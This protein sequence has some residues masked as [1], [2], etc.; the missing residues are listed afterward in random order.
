MNRAVAKIFN[1]AL[2]LAYIQIGYG[3]GSYD[4]WA[5]TMR[6][7]PG[8]SS[9]VVLHE[10]VHRYFDVNRWLKP[11]WGLRDEEGIAYLLEDYYEAIPL[12][13]TGIRR[14][15]DRM[16]DNIGDCVSNH[17][18]LKE[19][20]MRFGE[21]YGQLSKLDGKNGLGG[22]IN[23]KF[24]DAD[25]NRTYYFLNAKLDCGKLARELNRLEVIKNCCFTF[26]CQNTQTSGSNGGEIV[27]Q[28]GVE[29]DGCFQ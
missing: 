25:V 14:V 4:R 29:I 28:P 19:G 22:F 27:I 23:H 13:H 10:M 11:G 26:S 3:E 9:A 16:S 5:N 6:L 18:L 1:I 24:T 7:D 21:S 8:A 20:W 17:D 15:I 2:P 12:W